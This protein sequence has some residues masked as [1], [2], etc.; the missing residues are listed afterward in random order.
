MPRW[1]VINGACTTVTCGAPSSSTCTAGQV[2]V[3]TAF[4]GAPAASACASNTCGTSALTCG[5]LQSCTANCIVVG[6]VQAA[7]TVYCSSCPQATCA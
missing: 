4:A 3:V 1:N 2:C 6:S 5:C 7:F